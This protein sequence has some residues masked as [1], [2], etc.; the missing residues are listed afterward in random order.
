MM[1]EH[2][3]IQKDRN[4]KVGK[5]VIIA[6][7]AVIL[8]MTAVFVFAQSGSQAS[9]ANNFTY[10]APGQW[11]E[12]VKMEVYRRNVFLAVK[13][14]FLSDPLFESNPGIIKNLN[15]RIIQGKMDKPMPFYE[16]PVVYEGNLANMQAEV[17]GRGIKALLGLDKMQIF[18]IQFQL[19]PGAG[20]DYQGE[21]AGFT[22]QSI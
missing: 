18:Y 10:L 17:P 22:V 6:L 4:K 9:H 20:N 12:P 16:L 8:A 19:D 13:Q 21:K 3:N 11:T 1:I 14:E 15:V 2:P 5:S 7:A